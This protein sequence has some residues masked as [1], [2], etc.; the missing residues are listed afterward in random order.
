MRADFLVVEGLGDLIVTFYTVFLK[1]SDKLLF[2]TIFF[3]LDLKFEI[4][5]SSENFIYREF[6]A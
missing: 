6:K 3:G 2:P 1:F 4:R 5:N